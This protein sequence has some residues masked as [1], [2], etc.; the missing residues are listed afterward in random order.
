MQMEKLPF[1]AVHGDPD[2]HNAYETRFGPTAKGIFM[3]ERYN[4]NSIREYF[5]VFGF[6]WKAFQ[7]IINLTVDRII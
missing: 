4:Y 5:K 2:V 6:R 1:A 7:I 3:L